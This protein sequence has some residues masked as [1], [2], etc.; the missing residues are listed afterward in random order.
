[1]RPAARHGAER[2]G[3]IDTLLSGPVHL[4]HLLVPLML[5][6]A[7]IIWRQDRAP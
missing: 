6:H 1:M 4:N 7:M 2:Q 3:E 5:T